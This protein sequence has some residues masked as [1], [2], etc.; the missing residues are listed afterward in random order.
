MIIECIKHVAEQ[1]SWWTNQLCHLLSAQLGELCLRLAKLERLHMFIAC[2]PPPL[3]EVF[4]NW[5]GNS[6][7]PDP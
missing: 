7:C 4:A 6:S 5:T 2:V 1:C 3:V